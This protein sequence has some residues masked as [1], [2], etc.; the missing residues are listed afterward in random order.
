MQPR[1]QLRIQL[2]IQLSTTAT[3]SEDTKSASKTEGM[4][5]TLVMSRCWL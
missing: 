3:A 4:K 5:S 1:V 2:R